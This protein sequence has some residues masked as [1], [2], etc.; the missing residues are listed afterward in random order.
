MSRLPEFVSIDPVTGEQFAERASMTPSEW[1]SQLV[2]LERTAKQ[3]RSVAI[4]VRLAG[5]LRLAALLRE[6]KAA[7]S[8]LCTREMGKLPTEADDEIERSANW[9]E[10]MAKRVPGWLAD[11]VNPTGTIKR[12]PHGVVLAI[13][14]WNYPVWQIFRPLA[15]AV[16]T[17]NVVALKPAPNVAVVSA[18]VEALVA[19]AFP[20]PVMRCLWVDTADVK[21][22]IAHPDV[23]MV[24]LTGSEAAGRAVG[25]AAGAALKPCVLELG[26]NNPFI[27]LED[28]D[29]EAA[30]QAAAES[31]CLN[32]GQACTAAKRFFVHERVHDAFKA[33]LIRAFRTWQPGV[34]LAPLARS[35]I[36]V[37][38]TQQVEQSIA[39]GASLI[40]LGSRKTQGLYFAPTLLTHVS[41]GMPVFDEECFGPV[42]A[43][44]PFADI[45]EAIALANQVPQRLAA[46]IWSRDEDRAQSIGLAL[47]TGV[48]CVNRRPT[49]RFELPFAGAGTSGMGS[50]LGQDG[51]LAFTRPVGMM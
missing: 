13:T 1:Q 33:A 10:F 31:R 40:E 17:G 6:N 37:R 16:A 49:S 34:N 12:V 36:H 27:L 51:C 32:A 5:L 24:V 22:V 25:A 23:H 20:M 39:M 29:I 44:I 47:G 30:A 42:A 18:A 28:A 4:Q 38:L 26:G 46:A 43:L 50:T 35:D 7:L 2:S 41:P 21:D 19:E 11:E 9:C 8:D 3:W 15:A 14:P 45:D 48:V